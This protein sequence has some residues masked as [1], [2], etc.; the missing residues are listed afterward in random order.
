MRHGFV[1]R[2]FNEQIARARRE[3]NRIRQ[4]RQPVVNRQDNEPLNAVELIDLVLGRIILMTLMILMM[5]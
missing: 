1:G 2:H 3:E 5:K 4:N